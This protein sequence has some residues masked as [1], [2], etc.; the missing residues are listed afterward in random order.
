MQQQPQRRGGATTTAGDATSSE[1][2]PKKA[3]DAQVMTATL[4]SSGL[5]AGVD[6]KDNPAKKTDNSQLFLSVAQLLKL[7]KVLLADSE[8]TNSYLKGK[9]RK[10]AH[11]KH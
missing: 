4:I 11:F 9:F 7:L 1:K 6:R 5:I 3:P 10:I 8:Q 2:N